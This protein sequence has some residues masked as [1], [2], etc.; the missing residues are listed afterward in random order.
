VCVGETQASLGARV[1]GTLDHSLAASL[2]N[3]WVLGLRSANVSFKAIALRTA[4]SI[5]GEAMEDVRVVAAARQKLLS[6]GQDGT[7]AVAT[8]GVMER[9]RRRQLSL[10]LATVSLD[11]VQHLA[12]VRLSSE[13]CHAPVRTGLLGDSI[14]RR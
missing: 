5:I 10:Y 3:V 11:R 14:A 9:Q 8:L 13:R 12:A 1:G 2:F 6:E 4:A 7:E